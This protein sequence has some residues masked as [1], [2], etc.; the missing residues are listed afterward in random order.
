MEELRDEI[1]IILREA[2]LGEELPVAQG[3]IP[4]PQKGVRF[5]KGL[6]N[7][8]VVT[9]SERGFL[10]SGTRMSFE[11]IENALS[12][13]YTITLKDGMVLDPVKMQ[14]IMKYKNAF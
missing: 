2:L 14:Q 7:E 10:I 11:E 6:E 8:Y 1:S 5:N 9:F 3:I 12:K 4:Q 13:E